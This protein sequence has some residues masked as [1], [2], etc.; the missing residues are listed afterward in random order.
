MKKKSLK[1]AL[2]GGMALLMACGMLAGCGNS[3]DSGSKE[4]GVDQN[5]VIAGELDTSE[6]VELIMYVI[7]DRPAGQDVVDEN[8]NK[9]L[10]EKINC[11]LK[12]N[13]V[14]WAEFSNK[15]P[16]LFSSGES[17]DL[18]YC[19]T[20]LNFASLAQKSAFKNLDELWQS[21][22]PENFERQSTEAKQ[23]AV[24]NGHYY[25]VP[26][27]LSTY[28]A[29]G[30]IYRADLVEG[31]EWDGK[32][33]TFEDIEEYCDIIKE[34][35][36]EIE[37]IEQYAV[38]PQ[39]HELWMLHQG[40]TTLSKGVSFLWYDPSEE[41]PKLFTPY[42]SET[43]PEFL[44]MMNRW[45]EK[46]FYP[47]SALADTDSVKLENGK[48]AIGLHN[49]DAYRNLATQRPE[50]DWKF[51][52]MVTDLAH[53]SFTQDCIVVS[54]TAKYPERA[55]AFIEL[56]TNDQEVFDALMYGVEGV[57][58]ELNEE[59]QWTNLDA[60]L[61]SEGALWA[62]RTNEFARNP[63]GTPEDYNTQKE[64]F[65]SQI[66]SGVGAEKYVG[67][68]F[69]SSMVETEL[70]A[71]SNV[72]QQY[73]WPLELGYTDPVEGLAEYKEKWKQP[74][75]TESGKRRSVSLT[76]TLQHKKMSKHVQ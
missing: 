25:C 33:E 27:L 41:N 63:V 9:I 60:N 53:L 73:W 17:F 50:W 24:I 20:W 70:A 36:P 23:Q 76:N 64:Q 74:V 43:T 55:M 28:N 54:N 58:Y 40:Y 75:L 57:T 67:F 51:S 47:K 3:G 72:S 8:L 65:E 38:A 59:G 39:W 49:I 26:T 46:G 15:Y 71:C 16:L 37:P 22:A 45:N 21:Y 56:V 14:G 1:K 4:T 5:D 30:P 6:E 10:K 61:Y 52:N 29:Y 66:Q 18:A 31:T 11:T 12:I 42:E 34:T 2:A 32:M 48:A 13:W 19:A 68:V 7:G 44:E 62:A 35:H 69:D